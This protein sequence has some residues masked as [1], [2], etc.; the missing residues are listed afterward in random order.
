MTLNVPN[1]IYLTHPNIPKPL[2]GVNPRSIKGKDWWDRERYKAY[3]KHDYHCWAC[4][5][6]KSK[7]KYFQWLEGHEEYNIDYITGRVELKGIIALCHSCHNF[8][9]SGR[10]RMRLNKGEITTEQ[11]NDIL[12]HG[13][14][15]LR[16]SNL[17]RITPNTENIAS[18]EKWHLVIEGEKYYSPYKDINDWQQHYT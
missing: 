15:I 14:D 16:A 10:L 4:G 18:W 6:H 3:F 5:I 1:P 11:Y 17:I 9:H 13:M 8:I 2:H 7:A 12:C